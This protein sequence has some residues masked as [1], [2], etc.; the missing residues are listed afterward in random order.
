MEDRNSTSDAEAAARDFSSGK[1]AAV[2]R[3]H[4]RISRIIAYR[5]F[6]IPA[7]DR[8]DIE[9]DV[10]MQVWQASN[11]SSFDPTAGFWGFVETVTARRCIDWLR[12]QRT[13]K[14]IDDNLSDSSATPA[15]RVLDR[16]RTRLAHSVLAG[17]PERCRKLIQMH[18]SQAMTYSEIARLTS[19]SESAL[20][21]QM[22]RCLKQAKRDL[23]RLGSRA[24]REKTPS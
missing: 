1:P 22:H 3:V 2:R 18:A 11:R 14:E 12:V 9:Q 23:E 13:T 6:T 8:R 19:T 17:L 21:V 4:E 16:E 10:M 24:S 5:G 7:Q 15:R 20:R